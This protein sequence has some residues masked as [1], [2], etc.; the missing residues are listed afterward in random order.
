MPPEI[1]STH[2]EPAVFVD[3]AGRRRHLVRLGVAAAAALVTLWLAALVAGLLGFDALPALNLPGTG[4]AKTDS[5]VAPK[6]A[7]PIAV[8]AHRGHGARAGGAQG[9]QAGTGQRS[10]GSPGAGAGGGSGGG[11]AGSGGN[12]TSSGSQPAGG[13][14]GSGNGSGS[15]SGSGGG[16]TGSSGSS[17]SNPGQG[18]GKPVGSPGRGA[19]S[20][21]IAGS[22]GRGAPD[23]TPNGKHQPGS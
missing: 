10:G 12:S 1:P 16:T 21:N 20:E 3:R 6:K 2:A 23:T 7:F 13:T 4:P 19:P 22:G 17:G 9:A 14:T 11:N 8:G 18:G 5:A 15:G